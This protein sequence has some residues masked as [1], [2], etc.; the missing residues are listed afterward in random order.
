MAKPSRQLIVLSA[1]SGAGKTTL[2]KYLLAA[3][4]EF[5]FSVS[6]TTRKP[7]PNEINGRDYYFMSE[8]EFKRIIESD[9]FVEYEQIFDNY[10]GT[11]KSEVEN[12]LSKGEVVVFDIDV[13]GA[14]SIKKLY[15][16]EAFLIFIAPPSLDIL[17]QRLKNRGTESTEQLQKRMERIQMEMEQKDKFDYVLINDD[18]E[19]AKKELIEIV[20]NVTGVV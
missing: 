13:K 9:G 11:L 12:S 6:A 1:P 20:Q 18:I 15:P 19:R 16:K 7:R 5:K 8:E 2:A 17:Q 3:F 10:Y 4:P 14:L